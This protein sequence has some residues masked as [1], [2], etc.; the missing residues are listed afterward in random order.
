MATDTRGQCEDGRTRPRELR[1][2]QEMNVRAVNR[3]CIA[4]LYLAGC[5]RIAPAWTTAVSVTCVPEATVVTAFPPEVKLSV[6]VVADARRAFRQ[7]SIATSTS[8]ED[9]NFLRKAQGP[10]IAMQG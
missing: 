7:A 2:S 10:T 4:K 9:L 6:V 8:P 5:N 1:C 3:S